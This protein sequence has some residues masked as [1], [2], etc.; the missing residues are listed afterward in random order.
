[1]SKVKSI[2]TALFVIECFFAFCSMIVVLATSQYEGFGDG[3]AFFII[4][5]AVAIIGFGVLVFQGKILKKIDR[6]LS[7]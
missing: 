6:I 3:I 1:M 7:R 5:N 2:L 4:I